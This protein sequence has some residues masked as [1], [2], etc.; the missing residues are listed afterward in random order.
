MSDDFPHVEGVR[1]I[2]AKKKFRASIRM[3]KGARFA[4]ERSYRVDRTKRQAYDEIVQ[5]ITSKRVERNA[6]LGLIDQN[7]DDLPFDTP[8]PL[9]PSRYADKN[10][11]RYTDETMEFIEMGLTRGYKT[12]FD[13]RVLSLVE[14]YTWNAHTTEDGHVYVTAGARAVLLHRHVTQTSCEAVDH[15]DGDTMNNRLVNLKECTIQENQQ[16][17]RLVIT[18]KTGVNGVLHLQHRKQYIAHWYTDKK[19]QRKTFGYGPQS[20]HTKD[21]AFALAVAK[22]KEMDVINNCKNGIRPKKL[23]RTG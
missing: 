17:Q 2:T 7:P 9:R 14:K 19:N 15:I 22:R 23:Q 16:N 10:L 5:W 18:N 20:I 12:I 1:D 6:L 11:W 8:R 3:T 13:S 21:E 4:Y